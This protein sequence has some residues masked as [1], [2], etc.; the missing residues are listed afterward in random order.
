M[1]I[2]IIHFVC[3]SAELVRKM[4]KL[5]CPHLMDQAILMLSNS[6]LMIKVDR[7]MSRVVTDC[8]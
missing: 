7:N 5:R 2:Y 6:L 4:Q 1:L 3:S 8:V